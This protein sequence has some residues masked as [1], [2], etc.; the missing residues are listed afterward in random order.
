MHPCLLLKQ[1][2]TSQASSPDRIDSLPINPCSSLTHISHSALPFLLTMRKSFV[3]LPEDEICSVLLSHSAERVGVEEE[4]ADGCM[5]KTKRR[6]KIC[7]SV[8]IIWGMCGGGGVVGFVLFCFPK[9]TFLNCA[10]L[11]HGVAFPGYLSAPQGCMFPSESHVIVTKKSNY[12]FYNFYIHT[13][14]ENH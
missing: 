7:F 13:G 6:E 5:E 8:L 9:Q 11:K 2:D 10:M 4:E 1:H 14:T 3:P 12:R